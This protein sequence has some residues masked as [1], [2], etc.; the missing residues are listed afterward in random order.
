M[1]FYVILR[2]IIYYNLRGDAGEGGASA[3]KARL[4]SKHNLQIGCLSPVDDFNLENTCMPVSDIR[5]H[6]ANGM[7]CVAPRSG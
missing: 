5:Y 1:F 7:K 6:R 3:M 2:V 4:E